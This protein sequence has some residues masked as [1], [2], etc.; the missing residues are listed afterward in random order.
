MDSGL[1][2]RL[3]TV[4][5]TVQWTVLLCS[6]SPKSTRE[7]PPA[8]A[9]AGAPVT[10]IAIR[11]F[12]ALELA[13]PATPRAPSKAL[14]AF[15]SVVLSRLFEGRCDTFMAAVRWLPTAT[16]AIDLPP[17]DPVGLPDAALLAALPNKM[18]EWEQLVRSSGRER[19]AGQLDGIL[20]DLGGTRPTD[21]L[22]LALYV[23]AL[24]NPLP[25][26]G[27]APEIR[28]SV[29]EDVNRSDVPSAIRD[30]HWALTASIQ[31]MRGLP[32]TPRPHLPHD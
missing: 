27:V 16:T 18:D 30:V 11:P 31:N 13:V 26:L 24:V 6:C 9:V 15:D 22:A 19:S 23:A 14:A 3:W 28:G 5:W 29:L 25:A 2:T 17:I 10:Y 12:E 1:S 4:Q 21:P 7:V 32:I 20:C 8:D